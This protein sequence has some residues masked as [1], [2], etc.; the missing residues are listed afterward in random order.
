[1]RPP[2]DDDASDFS[3]SPAMSAC[4][5]FIIW[6]TSARVGSDMVVAAGSEVGD[7]GAVASW[8]ALEG[9]V[10]REWSGEVRLTRDTKLSR[11]EYP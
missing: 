4:V 10:G 11:T 3:F 6:I 2:L 8:C 5:S 1:V 9:T 7:G